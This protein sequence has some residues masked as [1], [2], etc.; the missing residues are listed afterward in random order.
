MKEPSR[1]AAKEKSYEDRSNF[2]TRSGAGSAKSS[3]I[4]VNQGKS[5]QKNGEQA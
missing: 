3:P 1:V 5:R 4:K 2:F